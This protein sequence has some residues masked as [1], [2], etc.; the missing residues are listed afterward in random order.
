[1]SSGTEWSWQPGL[2]LRASEPTQVSDGDRVHRTLKRIARARAHLDAQEAAALR[3]AQRIRLWEQF[4]YACL[5]DYMQRE[6]G[7]TAR[8][9]VERLRVANAIEVLPQFEAALD[10]GTLSF[11]GAKELT[12]V[13]TPETQDAWLEATQDKNVR[14]IEEMVSGHKPGDLPSDPVD[15]SLRTKVLRFDVKLDTAALVRDYQ[16]RRGRQLG[17]LI[18]DDVLLRE[19]FQLALDR[20]CSELDSGSPSRMVD[21]RVD[22]PRGRAAG[23]APTKRDYAST[24]PASLSAYGHDS[25]DGGVSGGIVCLRVRG[26]VCGAASPHR[27]RTKSTART[28]SCIETLSIGR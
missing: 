18:D 17:K 21:H 28:R 16:K 14:Q 19:V 5:V 25:T 24:S 4:G 7:Y 15:D 2:G 6:L 8:A 11:S 22:P 13:V 20:L 12:R 1:M 9:A 10:E 27:D 23:G 3:D 26:N